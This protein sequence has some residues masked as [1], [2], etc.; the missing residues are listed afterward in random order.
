[1]TITNSRAQDMAEIFRLYGLATNYQKLKFPDN[2]WP[3]FDRQLI[4]REIAE[5]RQFKLLLDDR[6]AC[7]WAITYNDPQIWANDD[8]HSAL[9]IHRIAT[10]PDF[11]GNNFVK[12][13]VDWAK[14]FARNKQYIRMDTC[15]RNQKLIQHY[16]NCG[17][18]FLGI[19]K[20]KDA[21]G[22]PEHYQN[23]EVC[24]FEIQL[25]QNMQSSGLP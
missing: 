12:I 17:F 19:K 16:Q 23:A 6:I 15:G 5:G 22:L 1:M 9:Y 24:Y 10:N 20:L 21:S 11:R 7:I 13:I 18:A 3:T 2:Q 4:A 25:K 8:G 14:T